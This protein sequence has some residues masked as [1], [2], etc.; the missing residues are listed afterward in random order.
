MTPRRT[1]HPPDEDL[2]GLSDDAPGGDSRTT[3][4]HVAS[5]VACR[6]RIAEL[7]ELR[8]LLAEAG[9]IEREPRF[10]VVPSAVKRLRLR[11]HTVTNANEFLGGLV[12][13]FRGLGSLFMVETAPGRRLRRPPKDELDA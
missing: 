6:A 3:R 13:L 12:A 8:V 2:L 11:R 4:A 9:A 1:A 7:R 10:N 5:C